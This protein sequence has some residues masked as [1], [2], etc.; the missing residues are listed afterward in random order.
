[1]NAAI[2][3]LLAAA[4]W[5]GPRGVVSQPVEPEGLEEAWAPKRVAMIVGIDRYDDPA[6]GSLRFASKDARDLA[7]VLLDPAAGDF[8]DVW[9]IEGRAERED[10]VEALEVVA[11]GL[12]KEDT[13][14][15]YFAGHG[16]LDLAGGRTSLYL[17]PSEA[18]LHRA[19]VEGVAL[20]WIERAMQ[21]LEARRRVLVVDACY[22]GSGRSAL[23]PTV[24][25]QLERLRGPVPAPSVRELSR[26]DARLFAAHHDQAAMEDP[27]L[28]NGVY[29]HFLIRALHGEGDV[30]GD[31]L[32]DVLE[33][34]AWARDATL[35]FTEGAQVPWIRATLVGRDAIYLAGDPADRS[36]AERAL[37]L[38]LEKLPEGTTLSVDGSP[39]GDGALVPG[40]HAVSIERFGE[41][42]LEDELWVQA[43][44][45]IDLSALV[46]DRQARLEIG[47]GM[48]W[49]PAGEV[50]PSWAPR[51][52]GWWW[53]AD[54]KGGRWALGALADQGLGAVDG[55]EDWAFPDGQL[56][57]RTSWAHAA[58]LSLGPV[59]GLGVLWRLP[60]NRAAQLGPLASVGARGSVPV[61]PAWLALEASFTAVPLDGQLATFPSL[62]LSSGLRR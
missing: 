3:L 53:P 37:L 18:R 49:I 9:V 19:P 23:A 12:N 6:L 7:E 50:M 28:E 4:A 13:F 26:Y 62:S 61:G 35:D 52:E 60:A 44:E 17:L 55:R 42:L 36:D 24:Q 59:A 20:A 32:V 30:D 16:T 21:D 8:D 25:E 56:L 29:T 41:A 46:R 15:L 2:L 58:G 51:I 57:L 54:S 39:R 48:S 43:G 10:L 1:M 11:S 34:H 45:R 47:L 14:L 22:A 31:D 40:V 33:A 27:E 38:G 5:A